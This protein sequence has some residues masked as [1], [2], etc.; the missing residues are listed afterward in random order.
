MKRFSLLLLFCCV[1]CQWGT[2]L[3]VK[4]PKRIIEMRPMTRREFVPY[5]PHPMKSI[6][7]APPKIVP[8]SP[9]PAPLT[10][11]PK[12]RSSIKEQSDETALFRFHVA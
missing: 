11:I 5:T 3:S 4:H 10:P 2:R 12:R 7:P 1:G 8:P 9:P 6:P